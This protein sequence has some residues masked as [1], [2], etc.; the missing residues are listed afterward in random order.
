MRTFESISQLLRKRKPT[1]RLRL[2]KRQFACKSKQHIKLTKKFK[3]FYV[4][5][6]LNKN[7]PPHLLHLF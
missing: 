6:Y 2:S 7:N 3:Y 4:S 5:F 1:L